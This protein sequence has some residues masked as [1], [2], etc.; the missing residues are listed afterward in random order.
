VVGGAVLTHARDFNLTREAV[1][2]TKLSEDTPGI[3]LSQACGTSLQAALGSAAKIATGQ[4]EVAIACGSDTVSDPPIELKRQFAKRLARV[5]AEKSMTGKASAFFS[6]FSLGDISVSPPAN[7]EPRTGLSM[8][9]HCELMAKEWHIGREEQDLLAF[10]SHKRAAA[11]YDAGFLDDLIVPAAGVFRDNNVRP[12]IDL[13]KIAQLKPAFDREAG[14]LTAANSTPLTDGASAVLLASEDWAAAH[15]LKPMAYL[16]YGQH[17]GI[18]FV[19][20]GRGLLMAPTVAVS[21]MLDRAGL[22]L[23]DFDTYE[24]HEA[25]AAQVLCTLKAWESP[26]YCRTM[27]GKDQPLGAIDR[28][29]MNV[30]GSSIAY[31]HPFAATGAR[32]LAMLAKIL[33]ENGGG[34]GLISICTAGGMGVCAILE[35]PRETVAHSE[36]ATFSEPAAAEPPA[37]PVYI[38]APAA[39]EPAG[40]PAQPAQEE[41]P[42]ASDPAPQAGS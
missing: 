34:R 19:D 26:D 28:S 29:K 13:E 32:I 4:I 20:A 11:A 21:K 38:E 8:G 17:Y 22:A 18:D 14:T 42:A 3:T 16:T 33:E 36:A 27:L 12:E 24:I 10:Q 7:A 39:P 1:I 40:A 37:Q 41:M 31:G 15:G 35:R 5:S 9:Q 30:K 25:F 6:G 2:G 23:Q